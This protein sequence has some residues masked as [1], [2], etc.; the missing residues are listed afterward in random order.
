MEAS[1]FDLKDVKNIP[2]L[3]GL[4]FCTLIYNQVQPVCL[5]LPEHIGINVDSFLNEGS[6]NLL[7]KIFTN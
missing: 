2:P 7:L 6:S 5:L 3:K 1:E 4:P